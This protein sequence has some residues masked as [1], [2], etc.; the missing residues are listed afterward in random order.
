[1]DKLEKFILQNRDAFD[2]DVPSLKVWAAIDQALE[3]KP[4]KRVTLRHSLRIAAAVVFLLMAG[5][6]AGLYLSNHFQTT[7]ASLAELAPEFAEL[8]QYYT[9]QVDLRMRELVQYRHAHAVQSDL[10]QLDQ[11]AAELRV[12]LA[13]APKGSEEQI[14][15]AMIYN[16]KA[17]LEIL[18]RVLQKIQSTNQ[19]TLKTEDDEISI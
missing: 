15:N 4:A 18:E 12:E 17:K 7:P 16:Y 3:E 11:V 5:A 8:E 2:D 10:E 14:I 13:N 1:M 9:S 19:G 6:A